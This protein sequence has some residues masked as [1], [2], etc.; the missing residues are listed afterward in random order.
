MPQNDTISGDKP[1]RVFVVE[2]DLWYG[3]LLV[4]HLSLNPDNQVQRFESA[5]DLMEAL[6]E[7][8]DVI[9]LDYT[10]P[11]MRGDVLYKKI[12]AVLPD[13]MVIM[14]SGQEDITTALN[15]LREGVYDYL[16]KNEETKDRLWNAVNNIRKN[17]ALRD[18]VQALREQI[19][20]QFDL[21]H[22]IIGNCEP[23]KKVFTL[24]A[25]AASTNINVS[26]SGETGT[27]KELVAKAIHYNSQRSRK[28]FVAVNVASIPRDLI[29]SEL[30]GHEKGSFTGAVA[31]RIGKFEEA[32]GGTLFLD[33]IADLDLALQVK[34][35]RVLQERE[36]SRIG[37][38]QVISFDVRIIVA[39]HKN[40]NEEVVAGRFREDLFYR[41]LG[42]PVELPPL[43]ERGN[44]ILLLAKHFLDAFCS[45]N[46]LH[47]KNFNSAAREKLLN[48]R[49]P[50]NV[51]E[52]KA[53]VELAAV[54]TDNDAI[55]AEDISFTAARTPSDLLDQDLTLD[56][57]NQKI[58]RH[59]LGRFDNNVVDV[60]R[61]L[62]IGKSTIYRMMKE[63]KL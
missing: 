20:H 47:K 62:G 56:E 5:A 14:I 44:D 6:N 32:N 40:L 11:D 34:L 18:E 41:L 39:T 63:G 8:P 12:R 45:S 51:R 17:L 57:F 42:L 23:M 21:Q 3:E 58:I 49:Y 37:S 33:E 24:I 55:D 50:G 25:K 30:F 60:A 29:E 61:R 52:L 43:K 59:Y 36:V 53:V 15:L 48:Y 38:N 13:A 19:D 28:P 10:L 35:L 22:L 4:H 7:R 27:G 9:T 2:D 16:V 31:T 26:V 46:K 1:L 54:M